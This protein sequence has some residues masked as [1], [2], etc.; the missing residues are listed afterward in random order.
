M[1]ELIDK[2]YYTL[3]WL[4]LFVWQIIQRAFIPSQFSRWII[5]TF[6]P[7]SFC[8]HKGENPLNVQDL[9][10]FFKNTWVVHSRALD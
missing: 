2:L 3:F 7:T 9:C 5:S 4:D 6:T 8:T 10:K 1:T